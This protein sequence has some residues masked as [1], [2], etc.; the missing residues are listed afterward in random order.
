MRAA[1]AAAAVAM[2]VAADYPDHVGY[3]N[4][5]KRLDRK[6]A[7]ETQL[8]AASPNLRYERYAAADKR[9]PLGA[10][11][12]APWR[13]RHLGALGCALSHAKVRFKLYEHI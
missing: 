8:N 6:C 4:L 3:I 9:E 1:A 13:T 7:I 2:T 10:V 5:D 11:P 12:I